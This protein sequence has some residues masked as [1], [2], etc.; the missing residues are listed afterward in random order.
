MT[1]ISYLTQIEFDFGNISRLKEFADSQGIS[2]PLLVTDKGLMS[3]GIVDKA[4]EALADCE[5]VTL[6]AG[7][8]SNPTEEAVRSAL[9]KYREHNCDGLIAIGGGSSIDLAKGVALLATHDGDLAHYAAIEGGV[10]KIGPVA[11]LIAVPT[12]AGTGS[13]VGRAALLTLQDGRKVG[14]ISPHIIPKIAVCD[15]ELT[16]GLP[17]MLTAATGLDAISHCIETYLSPKL[18]PVAEAIGL[19]GLVRAVNS[20]EK[21]VEDGSDTHARSEM[22]MAS[23]QGG[24][25]FQKGLGAIHGLSHPLGGLGHVNLHHGT[26]NAI[27][28]PP[29]LEFNEV[30]C[31]EKYNVMRERLQLTSETSLAEFFADLNLRLGLPVTLKE[32]GVLNEDLSPVAEAAVLDHSTPTNPRA[33]AKEDYLQ[34]LGAVYS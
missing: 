21:V 22:M 25:S 29:V 15:P 31:E 13:E 34:L 2:R 23:L 30:A 33:C 20:I 32:I 11:P 17:P 16:F 18:N 12:T 27:F 19:D 24:L 26:L 5:N 9:E 28:L 1:T 4:T 14:I 7:T 8:P 6:F 3:T 10:E